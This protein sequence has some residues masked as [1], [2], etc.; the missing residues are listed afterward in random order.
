MTEID[1]STGRQSW[2]GGRITVDVL[3]SVAGVA[4]TIAVSAGQGTV[5]FDAGDGALRDLLSLPFDARTLRGLFFTHGHYDHV[6]GLHALLGFQR[7]L[8]RDE[9]LAVTAP[10]GCLEARA[11][12][13]AFRTCYPDTIGF[14]IVYREIRPGETCSLA[15]LEVTANAVVH[16]G[17]VRGVGILDPIPACGYR[18]ACDGETVAISGDTGDCPSLR[19]LVRGVDLAILEATSPRGAEVEPGYLERVHLSEDLAEEI[20]GTAKEWI[21]I[22]RRRR[23]ES[24]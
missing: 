18:I 17:S 4:T 24:T 12:V 19:D 22:H 1:E 21:A 10:A 2:R 20:G 5:L 3:H 6:G 23:K 13:D 11:I 8:G 16:C 15:G 9:P 14:E 7:M